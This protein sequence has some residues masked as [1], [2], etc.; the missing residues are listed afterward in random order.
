MKQ[1]DLMATVQRFKDRK[2]SVL[3]AVMGGRIS[4]GI[5][6]PRD[7]LE[8]ALLMGIPYPKPSARQR[9]LLEYYEIKFGRGWDYTVKAPASRK[10]MQSIGRLY[11]TE[12]DR[13]VALIM[14]HR[15][16]QFKGQITGIRPA[17]N[18]IAEMSNFFAE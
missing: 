6:F 15:S 2:G 16:I 13:G 18:I 17:G 4:E 8:I 10:L 14:D 7:E 5:D 12:T 1:E 3:F 9:S 11:R